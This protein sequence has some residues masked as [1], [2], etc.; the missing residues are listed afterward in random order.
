[1]EQQKENFAEIFHVG[2]HVICNG[3]PG[4]IMEV[5][6]GQLHGMVVVR[7]ER[8]EVCVDASPVG[9]RSVMAA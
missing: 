5:C 7:L 8:G 4:T 1:M 6:D 2:Q 9:P 3:Y